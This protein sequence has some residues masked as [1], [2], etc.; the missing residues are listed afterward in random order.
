MN[1]VNIIGRLGRDV[2][3]R[4]AGQTSV[5]DLN[6]AVSDRRKVQG[7][8]QNV[9]TWVTVTAWGKTA[10]TASNYL[11]KGSEVG[12][13]GKL[14]IEEWTDKQSGQKRS[15]LKVVCDRLTLI[16]GRDGQSD[17]QRAGGRASQGGQ[18]QQP[19]DDYYADT[20]GADFPDDEVPF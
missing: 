11:S 2:E 10:E 15:K 16:G 5:A 17:G 12:I 20:G 1:S 7:E 9:T 4:Q 19:A 13:S 3:L 6:I 8:W 18:A 14:V